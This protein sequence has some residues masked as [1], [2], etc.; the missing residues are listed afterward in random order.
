[1][2]SR[3]AGADAGVPLERVGSLS[4]SFVIQRY[5]YPLDSLE[6][7]VWRRCRAICT[8]RNLGVEVATSACA[9]T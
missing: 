3:V 8:F 7:V 2:A 4:S 5:V 1:M 6:R 9:C